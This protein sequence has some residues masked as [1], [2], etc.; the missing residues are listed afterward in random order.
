VLRVLQKRFAKYG[1]RLQTYT[2]SGI[3]MSMGDLQGHLA[4]QKEDV[5]A[6]RGAVGCV[7]QD[8]SLFG[9]A[10]GRGREADFLQLL[11]PP[12]RASCM[13]LWLRSWVC[14]PRFAT[15]RKRGLR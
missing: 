10:L 8:Q 14:A 6:A 5:H 3:G 4:G 11:E 9:D 12:W 15:A 13:P 2:A 1:L 7:Q